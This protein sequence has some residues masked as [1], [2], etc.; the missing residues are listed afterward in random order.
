M[1]NQQNTICLFN[2]AG[3]I[4]GTMKVS[5]SIKLAD[6]APLKALGATRIELLPYEDADDLRDVREI[7]LLLSAA[8]YIIASPGIH[9][10]VSKVLAT[11]AQHTAMSWAELLGAEMSVVVGGVK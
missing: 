8:L 5:A 7:L 10:L 9:P 11:I 4:L 6:L 1:Q 2:M 3:E